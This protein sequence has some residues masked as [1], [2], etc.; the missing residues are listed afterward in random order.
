MLVL[1]SQHQGDSHTAALLHHGFHA[2]RCASLTDLY[3]CYDESP[4]PLV[5]LAGVLDHAY[6]ASTRL[7]AMDARLGIVVV[8]AFSSSDERVRAMQCGADVC[9]PADVGGLELAAS[10]QA[11]ARRTGSGPVSAPAPG[12]AA[13]D[14]SADLGGMASP[15][16][17]I[18]SE[19]PIANGPADRGWRLLDSGWTLASPLGKRLRLTT[20]ERAFLSHLLAAPGQRL[21][22]DDLIASLGKVARP[23]SRS[24]DD[25]LG[26]V[27]AS[28][29][30]VDV[31]VC[32][33][34]RKAQEQGISLPL[35]AVYRW[36]YMFV[37]D[38]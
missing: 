12:G 17:G 15:S 38:A 31:M 3:R 23:S 9:L 20:S 33:L 30:G 10:L 14:G 4:R 24:R 25:P 8:G 21:S 7:R 22:R 32:R 16:P 1:Q 6:M 29:R 11:L 36:G 34:R 13:A 26:G 27:S 19:P 5:V 2:L 37:E 18:G 35:R 28:L